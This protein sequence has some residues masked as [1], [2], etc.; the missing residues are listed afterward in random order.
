MSVTA[1]TIADLLKTISNL[2][3]NGT[4]KV[5]DLQ[6]PVGETKLSA[7]QG[8]NTP[9][10]ACET[11]VMSE[12]ANIATNYDEHG[13]YRLEALKAFVRGIG[14]AN[15]TAK[16]IHV[17]IEHIVYSD[18]MTQ[19]ARDYVMTTL[20]PAVNKANNTVLQEFIPALQ[21]VSQ[22][23]MSTKQE[24]LFI[25]GSAMADFQRLKFSETMRTAAVTLLAEIGA[26]MVAAWRKL[27]VGPGLW[28]G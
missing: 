5:G 9:P 15:V 27:A 2:P 12:L 6:M 16:H 1:R 23:P 24:G 28:S 11:E 7:L 20:L 17:L 13:P 8:V 10:N 4:F 18:M 19:E 14:P 26:P 25:K 3:G 21:Y 22:P